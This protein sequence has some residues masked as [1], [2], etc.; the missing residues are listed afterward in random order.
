MRYAARSRLARVASAALTLSVT[1]ASALSI[2][3]ASAASW[4]S[5]ISRGS[6]IASLGRLI[7][8]SKRALGSSSARASGASA[9]ASARL[10][11]HTRD[12]GEAAA[13]EPERGPHRD[14]QRHLGGGWERDLDV[15]E[16]ARERV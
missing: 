10:A 8:T 3:S 5:I 12:S 2:D 7:G 11:R 16:R 14:E 1:I 6:T 4:V 13:D 9:S 15:A